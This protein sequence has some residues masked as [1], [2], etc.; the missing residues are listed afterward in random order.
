MDAFACARSE[1]SLSSYGL[2]SGTC[3]GTNIVHLTSA[4]FSTN[5]RI[6]PHCTV[7]CTSELLQSRDHGKERNNGSQGPEHAESPSHSCDVHSHAPE[8][9]CCHVRGIP[10][11]LTSD[12]I[13][14]TLGNPADF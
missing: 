1:Q 7:H 10:K 5:Q 6:F 11:E 8:K 3:S 13:Q 14:N 12:E 9:R 4:C 2:G